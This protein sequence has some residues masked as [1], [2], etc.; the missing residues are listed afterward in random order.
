MDLL[1]LFLI[2]QLTIEKPDITNLNLLADNGIRQE[3]V[4]LP[5]IQEDLQ[6]E[7]NNQEI[8]WQNL[9]LEENQNLQAPKI[10]PN[11][12]ASAPTEENSYQEEQWDI[13]QIDEGETEVENN[14]NKQKKY[15]IS[16]DV[17]KLNL[18]A[19]DLLDKEPD[20]DP[21]NFQPS[22]G[23]KF[24]ND[25]T[26]T[27]KALIGNDDE[28]LALIGDFNN[29][30]KGVDLNKYQLKPTVKNPHIHEITLP[31]GNY[32]KMQYRLVD[33]N[34]NQRLHLSS[35]IV[36]T[37]AF[38]ERFYDER[39]PLDFNGV[40]WKPTP[41]PA[42]EVAERPDLRGKQLS[43]AETDI[44]SLSLKWTCKNP[45][46]KFLG[47]TGQENI[48]ELYRFVGEC[49][50]P[51][52]LASMGYN[53][54]Q[55]MPLDAHI[56]FW[57]PEAEYLP[58]WRYSYQTINYFGKHA[59]FGSPDELRY[60]NNAFHKAGV[61]V[62][63]DVIYSHIALNGNNPP[64][65]FGPLGFAQYKDEWGNELYSGPWTEW[66]T[67]RFN[68]TE[69][70]RKNL[71]DAALVNILE[72]GFDGLRIDNVNGIDYQPYGRTMLRELSEAM[73]R[74]Y[75]KGVLIGEGYFGDPYLNRSLSVG[76]GGM[77]TT[78]SDRFYLWFTEDIIKHRHEIDTWRLDYMLSNDWSRALLYYPGNHDEF[79]NPG[80][81]FQT[82]GRY[83]AQ[84]IDGG[85]FH[86]RKIQSWSALTLFASS[87]YL[88]MPQLW[89]LQPGNL[90]DNAAI[91]WTRLKNENVREVVNFQSDMKNFYNNENAFA[92]YNMHRHMVH[93]IDHENKVI[94]FDRID[95]SSGK[96]VYVA[97]NLGDK[98]LQN[99]Q[100]PV[101]SEDANYKIALDSDRSEY[102]G[103]DLNP[104]ETQAE[105]YQIALNIGSYGVVGLVQQDKF[106]LPNLDDAPITVPEFEFNNYP[107][108]ALK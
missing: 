23:V 94:I 78:Y 79:A 14:S 22:S 85:D 60:M 37:P 87:Y 107:L 101:H 88:D 27:I 70:V 96:H 69:D 100:I 31:P 36:S 91:D 57:E 47:Q 93:W 12:T 80:N 16:P 34:G 92:P 21:V 97:V 68:Y 38:N 106:I 42:E 1:S 98:Y 39:N 8:A 58:D 64:R 63:L 43:I 41:I 10:E 72:Y 19:M 33:Q 29:W 81:P 105:D 20:L 89:T 76:G 24:N 15:V 102:G 9:G 49:G 61:A 44:V 17:A 71:V 18:A 52:Q 77:T 82:R 108:Q 3:E 26:V 13:T 73:M 32:H 62:V 104:T 7:P 51:E 75:P 74:Y 28:R 11:Q 48:S 59:D 54:I 56:D 53:T 4:I 99:Y 5:E 45:E 84:A 40:L 2:S 66:G 65:Q 83:L 6:K 25:G 50:I 30:G 86:K 67:K 90:N 35:R 46:S 103:M 55:F 95:F